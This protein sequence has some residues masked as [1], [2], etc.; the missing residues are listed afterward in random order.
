VLLEAGQ[1]TAGS[2]TRQVA[3]GWETA[4]ALVEANAPYL[5]DSAV[6]QSLTA[7]ARQAKPAYL[8]HEYM[9][10][11]WHPCFHAD[12]ARALAGAKLAWVAS[13]Q[14]LENFTALMLPDEA[15]AVA[16]RYDDP[17]MRELIKDL[18]LTRSLRQDV[19]V[20]GAR[21]LTPAERDA[22]LGEVTLALFQEEA[23]FSWEVEVPVGQARFERDFFG[24]VVSALAAGPRRV[25]DLLALPGLPRRDNPGE[26]VGMLVG[27]NQA[28]PVLPNP[29]DSSDRA[30][31]LNRAAAKY[32][33]H[34]DMLDL[35]MALATSG[36]G[37]PLACTMLD[38]FV[39]SRLATGAPDPD[40][41]ARELGADQPRGEQERLREFIA[42]VLATRAPVWR[43]LGAVARSG[44]AA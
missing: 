12:V 16:A 43:R 7:Y 6:V 15:R 13:A 27:S 20:R 41:W 36:T 40:G 1:R 38:L 23:E 42:G 18:F 24:P 32:F 9:N 19:F 26:L 10:A 44:A 30:F 35:G 11:T 2:S 3:S 17:L 8:A 37:S 4:A 31:R 21:R 22:A 28:L 29:A 33:V 25:K 34:P 39:A 14:L 5:R